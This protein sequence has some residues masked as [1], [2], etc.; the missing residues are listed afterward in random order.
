MNATAAKIGGLFGVASALTIIPAYWVGTPESPKSSADAVRY[1]HHV[2]TF[3]TANGTL[4][5][6]HIAFG[7]VFCGVLIAVLRRGSRHSAQ[8]YVALVA[9][10]MYLSLAAAGIAAEVAVPAA[11][12]QYGD[13]TIVEYTQPFL[14]MSVWLYTFC[15]AAAATFIFATSLAI[16]RNGPL[17]RGAAW[18]GV[19]GVL[20]LLHLWLAL[21]SA[22]ATTA[23]MFLMGVVLLAWSP[24]E[25]PSHPGAVDTPESPE[26]PGT[27]ETADAT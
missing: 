25:S 15:H 24:Q 6:L 5:L 26:T 9:A 17:P 27:P 22:Y 7:A 2:A 10:S 14:A 18:L 16:A 12:Q 20:P 3:L 21:P 4:P 23:W 19:L 1:F 8:V 13:V 11:V